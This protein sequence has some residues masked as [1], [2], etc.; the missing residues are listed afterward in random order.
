MEM[1]LISQSAGAVDQGKATALRVTAGRIAAVIMP[2][3]MGA[4][5]EVASLEASFYF[6][7][8]GVLA[9]ACLIAIHVKRSGTFDAVGRE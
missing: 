4:V 5:V 7:G 2:V 1:A 9:L 3:I 8:G 6:M